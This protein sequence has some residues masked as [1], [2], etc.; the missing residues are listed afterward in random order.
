MSYF[1][2]DELRILNSSYGTAYKLRHILLNMFNHR[3][4]PNVDILGAIL[5]RDKLHLELFYKILKTPVEYI[6]SANFTDNIKER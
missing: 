4:Y 2:Q 1:T 6:N 5:D 3:T